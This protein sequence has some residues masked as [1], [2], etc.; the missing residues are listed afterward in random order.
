MDTPKKRLQHIV[1]EWV[2]TNGKL[3][4]FKERVKESLKDWKTIEVPMVVYR[5]QG[6]DITKKPD[7][8]PNPDVLVD[9]IRPVIATSRVAPS[10]LRYAGK[11]CCIFA[12]TLQAGTRYIDIDEVLSGDIDESVMENVREFCPAKG[13]WPTHDADIKTMIT[14]TKQR[15]EGRTLYKGTNYEEVIL[16]EHEIM[17]YGLG[18][19]FSSTTPTGKKILGKALFTVSYGPT[20]THSGRGRTFRRKAWRRNKKNGYRLTRKSQNLRNR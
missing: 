14:R 5:S 19:N 3:P 13:A 20:A 7:E 4:G 10:T 16:P 9:G 17:V 12:I 1:V 2:L 8:A 6:G 18:G 15:C 11:D